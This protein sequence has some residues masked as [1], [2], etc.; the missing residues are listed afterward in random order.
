MKQYPK[1]KCGHVFQSFSVNHSKI[2]LILNFFMG[3]SQLCNAK[4]WGI[5]SN[6]CTKKFL[7]CNGNS[8][9]EFA[10][11]CWCFFEN[12]MSEIWGFF[13]KNHEFG[14][15][16]TD[17]GPFLVH[18]GSYEGNLK[19]IFAFLVWFILDSVCK[20]VCLDLIKVSTRNI[21]VKVSYWEIFKLSRKVLVF[22]GIFPKQ[23]MLWKMMFLEVTHNFTLR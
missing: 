3:F 9:F 14:K 22:A 11:K 13:Y 6:T 7:K 8:Y 16:S 1:Q 5:Q 19:T 21:C 10:A 4:M 12:T 17:Q 15:I 18:F 20:K 23:K 2:Y